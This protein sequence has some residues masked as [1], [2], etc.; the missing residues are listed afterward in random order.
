MGVYTVSLSSLPF[1]ISRMRWFRFESIQLRGEKRL[2]MARPVYERK[3]RFLAE[4]LLSLL[5]LCS[6]RLFSTD[7][8]PCPYSG[9]SPCA[10]YNAIGCTVQ[11]E[12]VL[13]PSLY[14]YTFV[15][16]SLTSLN[17]EYVYTDPSP[18]SPPPPPPP[19]S[20]SPQITSDP[21]FRGFRGQVLQQGNVRLVQAFLI[22]I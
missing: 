6:G 14:I 11:S 1:G 10:R 3:I 4:P 13:P 22:Q 8:G 20:P 17:L 15:Y 18:P 9:P 19:P 16:I 7:S 5:L 12:I 21:H 2:G